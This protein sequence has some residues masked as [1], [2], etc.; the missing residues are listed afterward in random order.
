VGPLAVALGKIEHDAGRRPVKLISY[1]QLGWQFL[2]QGLD[3][4]HE[5]KRFL[6]SP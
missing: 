3:P 6:I 2:E 5:S 4:S 1:R